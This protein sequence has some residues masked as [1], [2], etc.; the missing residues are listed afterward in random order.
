MSDDT[1]LTASGVAF[2]LTS[3]TD[4]L[5]AIVDAMRGLDDGIR[6]EKTL[7]LRYYGAHFIYV[8]TV[9][10]LSKISKVASW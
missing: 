3:V 7:K 6:R 1:A 9:A 4:V 2:R 8:S 10:E 5:R